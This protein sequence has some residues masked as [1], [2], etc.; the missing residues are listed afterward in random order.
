MFTLIIG[1]AASGKSEFAEALVRRQGGRP[2]YIA[3][4]MPWDE[5][6]RRRIRKHQKR[7]A[8]D[9]YVTLEV[10]LGLDRLTED[11]L[12][13]DATVLLECMSNLAANELYCPEGAGADAF[14]AITRGIDWLLPRCRHLTVV[15]NEV[16]CGGSDY[17]GDT[18]V[19]LRLLARLNRMLARKADE[20][21][22]VVAGLPL[23]R[24]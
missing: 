12:P 16:F 7:R 8:R 3:T 9:G 22:E 17:E 15:S 24:K 6:C 2:V 20:A 5:E 14:A 21:Y 13:P 4:L 1:G 18:D 23:R 10:P 19:Y 11:A